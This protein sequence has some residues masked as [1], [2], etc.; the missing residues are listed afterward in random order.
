MS[1][2]IRSAV[3]GKR[4]ALSGGVGLMLLVGVLGGCAEPQNVEVPVEVEVP[5]V[6]VDVTGLSAVGIG[7]TLTLSVST[8]AGTDASYAWASSDETIATV[9][10]SGVVTGVSPGEV[11]VTATGADS[12]KVGTH[13]V[14]VLPAEVS[15]GELVPYYEQW[16]SSGHADVTAKAFTNWGE[17]EGTAVPADC[18]RCHTSPGMRDYLGADGSAFQVVDAPAPTGTTVDC[19][20]CHNSVTPTLDVVMFP[21]GVEVAGLGPEARCMTCHQGLA[22]SDTVEKM[23]VDN[24]ADADPDAANA[25]LKFTNIHYYAAGATLEAGRVRG[26][27]QYAGKVYDW[28]FRH[29]AGYDTCV[30]CHD[31][32]TLA[33]KVDDCKTCHTD[34]NTVDDLKDVRMIASKA[35]DYDGDGDTEEGIHHEL[36]GLRAKLLAEI[37]TYAA[38]KSLGNVC[39]DAAVYPY[40]FVDTDDSGACNGDE[41]KMTN[42]FRT[43]S[44]RL[45]RAAYNYQVSL[46]DPGAF[47]HNAKYMIQALYDSIEDLG[48]DVS[49]L[50][51]N[52]VG[53]FNGA[54]EANRHWDSGEGVEASCAQC[55]SGSAG[56]RFYLEFGAGKEILEQANGL[57]CATCHTSFAPDYDVVAVAGVTFP[58]GVKSDIGDSFSNMCATCHTGRAAKAT[59]DANIAANKFLFSNIHYLPAAATIMGK[60]AHVG[61]EF[62][63]KSYAGKFAHSGGASCT[64]CHSATAGNHSFSVADTFGATGSSCKTCHAAA[65]DLEHIRFGVHSAKDYDGDGDKTEPLKDE[66]DVFIARTM[67]ALQ[68]YATAQSKPA[69]C[70]EGHT[71]PYLFKD[72]DASGACSAEE[73]VNANKYVDFDAKM[74]RV[75]FNYQFAQKE[76]G[77]WA[78]NFDYMGQLLFDSIEHLGG[79]VTGLT[80]P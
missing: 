32:H 80:R 45:T 12:G 53:H 17:G 39:Y 64:S 50:V 61:Y 27:Y 70:Y 40:W 2:R 65:A 60:D 79:S 75:V 49:G 9:D 1:A 69:I 67:A 74:A 16:A 22:S 20:A 37:Q 68:S 14:V 46:K 63:A 15:E 76:P 5:E 18:A 59:V 21:S 55:H 33:V 8:V 78:H 34:V 28:R 11:V 13:N 48:G 25:A 58:S 51:R 77:A 26:A 52:D 4:L 24:N 62:D 31:P 66:L 56:F 10:A 71:Y 30:G 7:Q 29:V 57:D 72:T 6:R 23:I 36:E 41:A 44:A 42:Q 35:S 54:S 73:A 43:W 38:A 3:L 47:A 19:L